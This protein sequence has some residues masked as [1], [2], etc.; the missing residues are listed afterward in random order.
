MYICICMYTYVCTCIHAQNGEVRP[1]HGEASVKRQT[2]FVGVELKPLLD[3][4][5]VRP[6]GDLVLSEST[7]SPHESALPSNSTSEFSPAPMKFTCDMEERE[8]GGV[9]EETKSIGTEL[10]DHGMEA[11]QLCVSAFGSLVSS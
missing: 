2:S 1:H 6:R 3:E 7:S 9:D 11:S 10:E 5:A 8:G 4:T